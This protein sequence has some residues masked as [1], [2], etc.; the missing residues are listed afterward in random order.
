MIP[1]NLLLSAALLM[2]GFDFFQTIKA[3]QGFQGTH[4]FAADLIASG[5]TTVLMGAIVLYGLVKNAGHRAGKVFFLFFLF[6]DFLYDLF[7]SFQMNG[8]TDAQIL[9]MTKQMSVPL[10]YLQFQVPAFVGCVIFMTAGISFQMRNPFFHQY[11]LTAGW[12]SWAQVFFALAYYLETL[13]IFVLN[14]GLFRLLK[15]YF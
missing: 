15:G 14:T 5:L 12:Q 7:F 11:P 4:H 10:Y 9:E 3:F 1:L 13:L 2:L 8:K 6:L